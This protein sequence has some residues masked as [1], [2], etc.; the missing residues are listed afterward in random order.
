MIINYNLINRL[1]YVIELTMFKTVSNE[2][3]D[4]S[5]TASSQW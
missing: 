5:Q 1:S 4:I 3:S 2:F